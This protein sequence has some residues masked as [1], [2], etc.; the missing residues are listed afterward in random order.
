MYALLNR[1]RSTEHPTVTQSWPNWLYSLDCGVRTAFSLSEPN[2]LRSS[3]LFS[4]PGASAIGR[5]WWKMI[6]LPVQSAAYSVKNRKNI[7]KYIFNKLDLKARFARVRAARGWGLPYQASS[8]DLPHQSHPL[9]PA[10]KASRAR[11]AAAIQ[12]LI[13]DT[14]LVLYFFQERNDSLLQ[15][16]LIIWIPKALCIFILSELILEINSLIIYRL[17]FF[18]L[19]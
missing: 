17:A 14:V 15:Y 3:R 5:L 12:L 13:K 7:T 2:T 9:D 1:K 4:L 16:F 10:L 8:I 18:D 11:R 6:S 19:N